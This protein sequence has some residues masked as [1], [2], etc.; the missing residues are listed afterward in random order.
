MFLLIY[1]GI[2]S[3]NTTNDILIYEMQRNLIKIMDFPH[4]NLPFLK[5][6]KI[7]QYNKGVI[8]FTSDNVI[9]RNYYYGKNRTSSMKLF[10]I[11]RPNDERDIKKYI[12]G[13]QGEK[14]PELNLKGSTLPLQ[15]NFSC[16]YID[17]VILMFGGVYKNGEI[18]DKLYKIKSNNDDVFEVTEMVKRKNTYLWPKPRHSHYSMNFNSNL[19]IYGGN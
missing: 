11:K 5:N 13:K 10:Y 1:G 4:L 2:V 17:K 18:N 8:V 15:K 16:D 3:N 14:Y 6:P 7:I 12:K 19:L 9:E